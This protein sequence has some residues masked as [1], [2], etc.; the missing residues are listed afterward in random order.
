M[1]CSF[2]RSIWNDDKI[3]LIK[4]YD[5]ILLQILQTYILF[6]YY[7]VDLVNSILYLI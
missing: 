7:T 1:I 2:R 5:L 6:S 3:L 4:T